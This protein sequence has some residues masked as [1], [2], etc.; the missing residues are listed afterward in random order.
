MK[1]MA[2]WSI[3][4]DKWLALCKRCGSMSAQ[5]RANA[6]ERVKIVGRWGDMAQRT[7]GRHFWSN[8]VP[9]SGTL[10]SRPTGC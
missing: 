2:S 4:Q 10:N 9:S 1:F 3:P 6:G 8:G 5:E 7:G